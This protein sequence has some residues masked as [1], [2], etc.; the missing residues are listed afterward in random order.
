MLNKKGKDYRL[1]LQDKE[2]LDK[3]PREDY[4][5]KLKSKQEE[6]KN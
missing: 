2:L 3:R 6:L 4:K 5:F 1:R